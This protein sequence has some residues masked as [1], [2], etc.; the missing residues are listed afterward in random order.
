ML[1]LT[2][3]LELAKIVPNYYAKELCSC[4][5]VTEQTEEYCRMSIQQDPP[6][7]KLKVDYKNKSVSALFYVFKK[8]AY[9]VS[10]ED[11]CQI[12]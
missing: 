5:F 9:L 12:K 4:L 6:P 11:G 2:G 10:E 1:L 3:C 8:K 7:Q